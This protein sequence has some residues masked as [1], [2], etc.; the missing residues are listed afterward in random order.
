MRSLLI[1]GAHPD[2]ETFFDGTMAFYV[3]RGVRVSLVC[4]TRGERG[5]TA[6]LCSIDELP[7]VREAELRRSMRIV[8]LRDEDVFFLPYE[9][10]KL[11]KAPL[12]EIREHLV[13]IVRAVRP[14]VAVSFDPNGGNGHTDHVAMSR[15]L[16]DALPAAAD[17]R[18]YPDAGAPHV[19]ERFLW[20]PPFQPWRLPANT[21]YATNPGV[22]F[23][24]DTSGV[25]EVKSAA[26]RE[27]QTQFPGLGTLFFDHGS[28]RLTLN[29]EAFR[30]GWGPQPA[31]R[32]GTDLFEGLSE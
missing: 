23:L 5:S 8:G 14:Q 21:D 31:R 10:Q 1:C 30:L 32:P 7:Q 29:Q 27:H 22:D 4:G 13:R 11:Y 3:R 12:D 9:D 6:D 15:A 17:A 25:A 28:P 16:L 24:I 2:D 26:I 18:W 20:L 19:V